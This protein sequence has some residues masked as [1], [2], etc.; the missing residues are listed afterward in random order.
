MD[1]RLV[2][3]PLEGAP[4]GF[5][6][7]LDSLYVRL[8]QLTDRRRRQG[9]RYPLAFVLLAMIVAKLGGADKPKAIAEWVAERAAL[10][11]ET[12]ELKRPAMP[13]HNTYRRGLQARGGPA[14]LSP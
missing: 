8:S 10:F 14:A 1:Y 12:F 11:A 9:T 13:H 5:V 4:D 6:F 3:R 2:V 7:S